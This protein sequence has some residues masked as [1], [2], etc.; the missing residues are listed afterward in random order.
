MDLLARPHFKINVNPM[1]NSNELTLISKCGPDKRDIGME[2][3]TIYLKIREKAEPLVRI[4][5]GY[6]H[7]YAVPYFMYYIRAK[8]FS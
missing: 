2:S 6:G 4:Q 1:L 3:K 8:Y 5:R 7:K